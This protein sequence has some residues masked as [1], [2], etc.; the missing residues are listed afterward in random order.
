MLRGELRQ[1]SARQPNVQREQVNP[2]GFPPIHTARY[3]FTTM[4][5]VQALGQ[6]ST[7]KRAIK[8]SVKSRIPSQN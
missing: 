3:S 4:G 2:P 1:L 7:P 6:S 8:K 5:G